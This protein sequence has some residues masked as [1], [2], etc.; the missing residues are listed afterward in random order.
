LKA[1]KEK[2]SEQ[3][4]VSDSLTIVAFSDYAGREIATV[5]DF[6]RRLPRAPDLFLYGGDP[7]DCPDPVSIPRLRELATLTKHR[8]GLILGTAV[9]SDLEGQPKP[10]IIRGDQQVS[11]GGVKGATEGP[12]VVG[13]YVIVGCGCATGRHDQANG[14]YASQQNRT[15][16]HRRSETEALGDCHVIVL[17]HAPPKGVCDGAVP[18]DYESD[19]L[20]EFVLKRK[21]IRLVVCGG[22]VFRRGKARRLGSA[23][24]VNVASRADPGQPGRVALIEMRKS[25]VADV[26][27]TSLWDLASIPGMNQERKSSLE[28]AGVLSPYDLAEAPTENIA[29][30][31]QAGG[32]EAARL[33][34]QASAFCRQSVVLLRNFSL[35]TRNR[36]YLTF[37]NCAASDDIRL[38]GLHL[39]SQGR[40]KILLAETANDEK[41]VLL[42]MLRLLAPFSG[43]NLICYSGGLWQQ[44]LLSRRLACH[45]LPTRI[46]QSIK[47]IYFDVESCLAFPSRRLGLR[48]V[49]ECCGFRWRCDQ[50]SGN[51]GMGICGA[52]Q[53]FTKTQKQKLV[54]RSEED[55][56]ALRHVV[57][58][59]GQMMGRA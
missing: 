39:E 43:L 17:S 38:V 25:R 5:I 19:S 30:A 7:P 36:A 42:K 6:V 45:G 26:K 14:T 20:R 16:R 34:A 22:V 11:S 41:Q 55:L 23:V 53:A 32:S 56:R 54:R 40:T 44:Q 52:S 15:A 46:T 21:N 10:A 12:L 8:V 27:W 35:P 51:G 24:V 13:N 18:R 2:C 29:R 4:C 33:R 37:E 49:A 50:G 59:L 47:D 3:E 28:K 57:L 1:L 58:Y 48:E 9:S 31:I